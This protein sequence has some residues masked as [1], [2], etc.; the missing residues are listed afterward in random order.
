MG[1][2]IKISSLFILAFLVVLTAGCDRE[3]VDLSLG[4]CNEVVSYN[5]QVKPLIDRTCAT[6]GCHNAGGQPPD[7]SSYASMKFSLENT[8]ATGF[9]AQ[10]IDTKVMPLAPSPPLD[11]IELNLLSCWIDGGYLE[12]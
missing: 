1:V 2:Y 11:S 12:D 5:N 7:Y 10:V 6:P 3:K 4:D 8:S 9:R